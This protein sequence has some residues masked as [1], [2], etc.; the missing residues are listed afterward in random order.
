MRVVQPV[1]WISP[2]TGI[3]F[4]YSPM[5]YDED[6][7]K[8]VVANAESEIEK[9]SQRLQSEGH[10]VDAHVEVSDKV[11]QAVADFVKTHN[12]DIVAMSTHGRG[13]SRLLLGSVSD[14]VLRSVDTPMLLHRPIAAARGNAHH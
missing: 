2:T 14:K 7:T 4:A 6:L 12:I 1:V 11:A 3:P 10:T 13:A 5:V 8:N 9:I